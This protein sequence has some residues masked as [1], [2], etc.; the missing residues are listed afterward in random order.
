MVWYGKVRYGKVRY[1]KSVVW[2]GTSMVWY[3][4]MSV[5]VAEA[6]VGVVVNAGLGC[7]G[8]AGGGRWMVN[9]K[10]ATAKA[11]ETRRQRH[12]VENK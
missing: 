7:R 10:A 11:T 1:G 3:S 5:V 8:G 12:T 9:M 2:Y 4:M 6:A